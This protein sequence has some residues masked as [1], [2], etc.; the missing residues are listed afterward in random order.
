[1]ATDNGPLDAHVAL[2]WE[3][4]KAQRVQLKF[5]KQEMAQLAAARF[6]DENFGIIPDWKRCNETKGRRN[7]VA[8]IA[9]LARL[10]RPVG[11]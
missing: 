4:D 3:G 7:S 2:T 11:S 5:D 1:M 9:R 8:A 10:Y 6:R